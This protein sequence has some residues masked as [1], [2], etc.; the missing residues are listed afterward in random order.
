[1]PQQLELDDL[2]I[3]TGDKAQ[4]G[5][6]GAHRAKGLLMAMAM[7]QNLCR[8]RRKRRRKTS[9]LGFGGDEFLKQH[10]L[11]RSTPRTHSPEGRR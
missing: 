5:L 11:R 3:E 1:M 2:Q 4:C 10:G 8:H 6:D 9:G 7:Q